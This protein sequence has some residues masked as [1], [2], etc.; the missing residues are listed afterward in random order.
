[1]HDVLPM[2]VRQRWRA[3]VSSHGRRTI[4]LSEPDMS[5]N[6]AVNACWTASSA[7]KDPS[8]VR[9]SPPDGGDVAVIEHAERLLRSV[10]HS[11]NQA[12]VGVEAARTRWERRR[13]PDTDRVP[14]FVPE[15]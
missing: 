8:I 15:R 4:R 1:M 6:A 14:G 12:L 2:T 7:S 3:I 13:A 11:G 10:A 5:T 9:H